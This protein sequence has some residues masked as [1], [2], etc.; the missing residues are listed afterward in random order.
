MD[1]IEIDKDWFFERLERAGKSLR[2]LA[3]HLDIDPSA[4][5]R[6]FSGQRHM[7]LD[8]A[9]R[10]ARFIG[11]PVEEVLRRAGV[12]LTGERTRRINFDYT[13]SETGKVERGE[14]RS[15]PAS[16][17]AR[18]E[19]ATTSEGPINAAQV[20]AP[21]GLLGMFDDAL[22]LFADTDAVEPA[23]VG[24]LSIVKLRDGVQMIGHV[25]ALRKTGEATLRQA[26]GTTKRVQLET[27][28]PVL[29]VVP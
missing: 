6:L 8:E 26:D 12:K 10:I 20:R 13:I 21:K 1:T 5:S 2:G 14:P 18:V 29:V 23:A 22:V 15:L 7:K 24:V 27:A 9:E 3:R 19:A 28:T 11:E 17:I 16:V 25:E 4:A